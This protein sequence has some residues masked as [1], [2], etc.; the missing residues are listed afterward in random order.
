[1]G[2]GLQVWF[3]VVGVACLWS[4]CGFVGLDVGVT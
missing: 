4:N 1:M 3:C 2:V